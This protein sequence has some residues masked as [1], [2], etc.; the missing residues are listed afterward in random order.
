MQGRGQL[1]A[2][3]LA[4]VLGVLCLGGS[5]LP[6]RSLLPQDPRAFAPLSAGL[7][8]AE[9]EALEREAVPHRRDRLLQFL[10]Y[11]T[12]V[13]QAWSRG[14]VPLW[15]P[16]I[17]CGMP[18]LAQTTSRPFYPTAL[19]FALCAPATVYAWIYLLHLVLAGLFAYRL[20]LR[21]GA[22][23]DGALLADGSLVLSGYAIAHLHHPMIFFAAVWT[24]PALE[25][26]DRLLRAP[27][28]PRAAALLALCV[29]LSWTAGFSQ[30]SVLLAY[31]VVGLAGLV[32]VHRVPAKR[33][34]PI[35]GITWALVGTALGVGLAMVQLLPALE[36]A[37]HSSRA[38]GSLDALAAHA[39]APA[40]L[41]EFVLPGQLAAPGDICPAGPANPRPTWL[42]LLLLPETKW[43][44]LASGVFNHTETAVAFGVWPLGFA[45]ATLPR[46]W[47]PGHRAPVGFLW[48]AA[49]VG[50][51][52]ALALPGLVH[53]LVLLPG[54]AVGDLKRLLLLPALA[55]PLLAGIGFRP[56][57]VRRLLPA[58]A[59]GVGLGLAGLWVVTRPTQGFAS[60]ALDSL[61]AGSGVAREDV[62]RA[63]LPGE[64]ARNQQLLGRGLG[65]LGLALLAGPV[66]ARWLRGAWPFLAATAIELLPIAL[67]VSP[68]PASAGLD[69]GLPLFPA[70]VARA[71]GPPPRLLR[72][73]PRDGPGV[74]DVRLLPPNLPLCFGLADATGYAPLPP[75]RAERFFELLEPGSTSGGA[76]IGA[77]RDPKTLRSRLLPL[78]AL[79]W[80]LT[81]APAVADWTPVA[82]DARAAL[83]R[84]PA[85][86]PRA[87]LYF[88]ARIVP[89]DEV[90]AV[91]EEPGFDPL[92]EIVLEGRPPGDLGV[93]D[94]RAWAKIVEYGAGRVRI[95]TR[96][97]RDAVLFLSE[98]WAPGWRYR[99]D[100]RAAAEVVPAHLMFQAVP[101]AAGTREV[102]LEYAPASF[103]A[104]SIVSLACLVGVGF[105]LLGPF[106]RS[107]RAKS[108][109]RSAEVRNL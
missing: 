28:T 43:P 71:G 88:R 108:A 93:P 11:D 42:S 66:L 98:G 22:S 15:E 105:L 55:L 91:L 92:A 73:E 82:R 13:G 58:A 97:T 47:R 103:R 101:V 59:A 27:P 1:E 9:I 102:V 45:L 5:L 10:P 18:L 38:P 56:L 34:V 96:T 64:L 76:G 99:M 94:P 24:L 67:S 61:S 72:L 48:L 44:Q 33:P 107:R 60:W 90:A 85:R 31:L 8:A 100:G 83:Y 7:S 75:R 53:A 63:F 62:A 84:P 25:C 104:G 77:L 3:L 30:A 32:L 41:L 14:E 74:A 29:A 2:A 95:E 23:R 80:L 36:M 17:L 21:F 78:L 89:P 40:H 81:S 86:E 52:G 39:L 109:G 46:L 16:R 57:R 4:L 6:G 12:A 87:R 49:V 19:L 79:D 26:A 54:F 70:G 35:R 65:G 50:L 69:G 51:G 37:R 106:V 20:A 68:A